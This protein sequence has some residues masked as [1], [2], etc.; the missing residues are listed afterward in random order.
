MLYRCCR[1]LA[2]TDR[3]PGYYV[4]TQFAFCFMC[5]C[6]F[7]ID[8]EVRGLRVV[9]GDFGVRKRIDWRKEGF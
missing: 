7:V 4:A 9:K 3:P 5:A 6:E 1:C 8:M 2:V